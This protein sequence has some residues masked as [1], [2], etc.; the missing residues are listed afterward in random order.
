MTDSSVAGLCRVTVRTSEGSVDLAVP[1]DIPFA[2]LLPI[3]TGYAGQE[4]EELGLE[5]GGWVLQRLGGAPLDLE[6]T[7]QSLGLR[8]GD[9]LHLRPRVEALPEAHFD[10]VVDGMASTLRERPHQWSQA[11]TRWLLRTLLASTVALALLVLALPGGPVALRAV[12]AA[13][14]GLLLTAGAGAASRAMADN[15]TASALA[16]TA[17]PCLALTGWLLPTLSADDGSG[18]GAT[19]GR[20]LSAAAAWAAGA[21]LALILISGPARFFLASAMVATAVW[22]A[23]LLMVLF[24]LTAAHAA[25]LVAVCTVLLGAFVPAFSFWLAGLRMPPLPTNA[26]ELQQGIDPEPGERLVTRTVRAEAWMTVLYAA[27][28]VICAGALT[29]LAPE[30]STPARVTTAVLAL[31]LVLHSRGV[32]NIWQR[33]AVLFPGLW[34]AGV[35]VTALAVRSGTHDRL[36]LVVLLSAAAAVLAVLCWALPGRR[37]VPHWGRAAELLHSAAAI[38]LLPLVLWILGVYGRMRGV[39]G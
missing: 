1:V 14:L 37:L 23:A 21:G 32:G 31:L 22:L 35:L 26:G 10:D 27:V 29:A 5:H 4:M 24:D 39:F 16:L 17:G 18:P 38:A 6:A 25:A 36:L 9:T 3:V 7:A 34:G 11:A 28:G 13:L 2:D 30:P 20:L 12:T 8:D 19:G 15:G 33:V